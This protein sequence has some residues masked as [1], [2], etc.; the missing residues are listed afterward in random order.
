MSGSH[1]AL[2][3]PSHYGNSTLTDNPLISTPTT[4]STE[5]KVRHLYRTT[6]P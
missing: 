6:S 3:E 2:D 5:P 4:L 1:L